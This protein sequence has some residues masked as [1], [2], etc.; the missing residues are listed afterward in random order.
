MSALRREGVEEVSARRSSRCGIDRCTAY[1]F[2]KKSNENNLGGNAINYYG[3]KITYR[4]LF[5]NI[6]E[7]SN[8]FHAIG[9][10]QDRKSV[11]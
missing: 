6:V 2:L 1:E 11:V 4:S 8:A 5:N 9:V 7:Y 3:R 10:K